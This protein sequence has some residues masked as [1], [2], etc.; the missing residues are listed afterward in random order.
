M[1]LF[2]VEFLTS[3]IAV[4]HVLWKPISIYK[5]AWE[6]DH[7]EEKRPSNKEV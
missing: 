6:L 5:K 2:W 4:K 3:P 7:I 1:M